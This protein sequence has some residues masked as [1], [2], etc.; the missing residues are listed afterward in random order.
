MSTAVYRSKTHKDRRLKTAAPTRW[1]SRS[2]RHGFR[3]PGF[4]GF[5]R[6]MANPQAPTRFWK[7]RYSGVSP[8]S[9]RAGDPFRLLRRGQVDQVR[10]SS[11]ATWTLPPVRGSGFELSGRR[12]LV[13]R[14]FLRW[15]R[16]G[17]LRRFD[18]SARDRFHSRQGDRGRRPGRVANIQNNLVARLEVPN[19]GSCGNGEI[20]GRALAVVTTSSAAD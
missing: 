3:P 2:E 9:P 6:R 8:Y 12:D 7:F 1:T 11:A 15:N 18:R 16:R 5:F 4:L 17:N 20:H 10:L 13:F 19:L 14:P